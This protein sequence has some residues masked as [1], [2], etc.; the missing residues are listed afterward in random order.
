[1]ACSSGNGARRKTSK[2]TQILKQF[3]K[4]HLKNKNCESRVS[5]II[6]RHTPVQ[7]KRRSDRACAHMAAAGGITATT[8]D[9][10]DGSFKNTYKRS[11]PLS[12][13]ADEYWSALG[14]QEYDEH[15]TKY[16]DG[17]LTIQVV[18]ESETAE[19]QVRELLMTSQMKVPKF[20]GGSTKSVMYRL[21]QRKSKQTREMTFD[22]VLEGLLK[23]LV[24]VKGN[25]V[26]AHDEDSVNWGSGNRGCIQHCE[27][28]IT[29]SKLGPVK[30]AFCNWV[31]DSLEKSTKAMAESANTWPQ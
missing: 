19:N 10:S 30:D 5:N 26:I 28:E 7:K 13:G 22:V 20:V 31:F 15:I 29:A 23:N 25:F 17:M 14:T 18:G 9:K 4:D 11:Y 27:F 12:L 16:M 8:A 1:M 24:S 6:R 21:V 2:T 3:I